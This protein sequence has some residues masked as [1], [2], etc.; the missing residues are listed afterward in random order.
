MP[1]FLFN[2]NIPSECPTSRFPSGMARRLVTELFDDFELGLEPD[3]VKVATVPVIG[4]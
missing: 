1:D 3:T 4:L 2:M